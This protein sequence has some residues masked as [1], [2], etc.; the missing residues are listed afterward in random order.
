MSETSLSRIGWLC[1]ILLHALLAIF[2]ITQTLELK[3]FDLDF[4]P[5]EFASLR[6][7]EP[8][9]EESI[10]RKGGTQPRVDLPKRPMLEEASPLLKLPA[11]NR[12]EVVAQNRTGKPDLSNLETLNP[13]SRIDLKP[14]AAGPRERAPINPLPLN[15]QA[16]YGSRTDAATD[17]IA[18]ENIFTITWD[19]PSR[20][21]TAGTPPEFPPG[22]NREAI[23]R[24]KLMVAPDG[25]ITSISPLTKGDQ[26][27]ERVSI[28]ALRSW[29]FNA[30]DRSLAQKNQGGVITFIFKLE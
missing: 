9:G 19:G 8:A 24:L 26:E 28:E 27:L 11:A 7:L 13:G 25:S 29:R 21:K 5:V 20:V 2:L 23:V 12:Q 17:H 22:V 14:L 1:S 16:L 3:P 6:A 15:D 4:T 18:A 10:D 30:L